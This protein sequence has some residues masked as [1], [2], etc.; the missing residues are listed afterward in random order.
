M[1]QTKIQVSLTLPEKQK[2]AI[3]EEQ[4]AQGKIL[5]DQKMND[6]GDMITMYFEPKSSKKL[7]QD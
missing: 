1:L 3:I 2:A 7:L 5:V 6:A 4:K